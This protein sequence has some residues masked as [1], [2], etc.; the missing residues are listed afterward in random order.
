MTEPS[1]T[2][3]YVVKYATTQGILKLKGEVFGDRF[4]PRG[5]LD[6]MEAKH[7]S[8]DEA[9]AMAMAESIRLREL[10]LAIKR[11]HKLENLTIRIHDEIDSTD[12]TKYRSV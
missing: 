5:F 1:Y 3:G 12:V 10:A 6:H 8:T 9:Q 2:I 7:W 4:R 11:V